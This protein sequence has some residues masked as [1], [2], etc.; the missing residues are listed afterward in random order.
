MKQ[1]NKKQSP[2]NQQLALLTNEDSQNEDLTELDK[3]ISF[4]GAK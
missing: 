3:D 2:D 1:V 4:G